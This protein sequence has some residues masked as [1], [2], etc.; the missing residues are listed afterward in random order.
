[1]KS[2]CNKASS[3]TTTLIVFWRIRFGFLSSDIFLIPYQNTVW[4]CQKLRRT[5][6]HVELE[7]RIRGGNGVLIMLACWPTLHILPT[8]PLTTFSNI[9]KFS[10]IFLKTAYPNRLKTQNLTYSRIFLKIP[11]FSHFFLFFPKKS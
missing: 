9:P 6:C 3:V 7:K 1:M 11:K 4:L 5:R 2:L 10:Q 8:F